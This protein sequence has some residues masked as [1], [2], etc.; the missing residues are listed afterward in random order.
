MVR[1]R[2]TKFAIY[3]YRYVFA[4]TAFGLALATLLLLAGLYLP[5]GLTKSEINSMLISDSIDIAQLFN[6]PPDQLIYLPYRLLQAASLNLFGISVISIKLPSIMLGFASAV[7][8]LYLLNLWYKKSVAIV[9]SII[10]VTTGQFLLTSQAGQAGISYVFLT[11]MVLI[12]A[13]M[14]AR[15]SAYAKVW[16]IAGFALAAASLY[17]P[18]NVYML[19][20]LILTAIVH[21]HARY[22]VFKKSSKIVIAAG[23]VVA[24]VVASPLIMGIIHDPVIIS[25]LFGLPSSFTDIMTN[26][27]QL[28]QNYAA[29][30]SPNSSNTLTPIYGLGLVILILVGV[31]QLFTAKYTARSYLISFWLAA[32]IPLICLNPEF[33]SITFVPVMLLVALG[34]EYLIVSW[35]QLFPKNPYA[36]VFGLAPL[37]ILMIGLVLSSVDRYAYGLHYDS[38]V[39]SSYSYDLSLLGK[40]LKSLDNDSSV[41]LLVTKANYKFYSSF[42]RH[43]QYVKSLTVV[44]KS[45]NMPANGLLIAERGFAPDINQ[46]PSEILVNRSASDSNRFYL[47]KNDAS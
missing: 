14:I 41:T 23:S 44:S 34:V 29:F 43:Q 32:L 28:A 21:P 18:L 11:I 39:Y 3:R 27:T 8:L 40:K 30:T 7:G 5:G 15:Q 1:Q 6:L 33:I 16:A 45:A 4:Y 20:A 38:G 37:G 35:Y 10:A 47:Y 13:S 24:L 22:L 36:R 31:Y 19:L 25:K 42:T 46:I 17:M 9:A 2:L 26:I 12:A